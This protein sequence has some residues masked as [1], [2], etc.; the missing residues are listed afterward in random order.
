ML[1]VQ[2]LDETRRAWLI[3]AGAFCGVVAGTNMNGIFGLISIAGVIGASL[4]AGRA[5]R[6]FR[7]LLAVIRVMAVL[8]IVTFLLVLPW[9]VKN[10]L[11]TG[12][13]VYPLLYEVFGGLPSV[14]RPFAWSSDLQSPRR[15]R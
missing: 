12:N 8:A 7:D 14:L 15:F 2:Y 13:P 9:L 1:A 10:Y 4:V 5:W 6:G 11:D 3:L